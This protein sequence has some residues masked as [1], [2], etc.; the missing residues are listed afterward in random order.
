MAESIEIGLKLNKST[1][2]SKSYNCTLNDRTNRDSL[3]DV[4]VRIILGLLLTEGDLL[5]I[6]IEGLNIDLNLIA[7]LKNIRRL[8][9]A[10]P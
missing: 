3:L 1:E 5:C 2:I 9:V 4:V 8:S 6:L 10:A 7:N